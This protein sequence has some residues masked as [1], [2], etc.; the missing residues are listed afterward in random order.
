MYV[1]SYISTN[2]VNI[3]I[4]MIVCN[5]FLSFR[6]NSTKFFNEYVKP[7]NRIGPYLI[8]IYVGYILYRT[9]CKYRINKVRM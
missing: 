9:D 1:Y 6:G 8:G 2:N 5:R 7:W 4:D 3:S